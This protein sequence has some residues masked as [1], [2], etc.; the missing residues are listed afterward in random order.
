MPIPIGK[1]YTGNMIGQRGEGMKEVIN[2]LLEEHFE[3]GKSSLDFSC[4]NIE[5]SIE[6]GETKEGSFRIYSRQGS[7]TKGLVYTTDNRMECL[8]TQFVGN[9]EEIAY[10]FHGENVR[11]GEEIKGEFSIISN[12]GEYSLPFT[13]QVEKKEL[14]FSLG[15]VKNLFHFANLAK[16]NPE[17]AIAAFYAPDFAD[18]LTGQDRQYREYYLGLSHIPG[19]VENIEEFLIGIHKKQKIEYIVQPEMLLLDDPKEDEEA[20][21]MI[22]RNGWGYTDLTVETEGDFICISRQVLTEQDFMGNLCRLSVHID[23]SRLHDGNNLGSIALKGSYDTVKVPVAVKRQR[24]TNDYR[25][26][27]EKKEITLQLMQL[28]LDFRM[29]KIGAGSWAKESSRLTEELLSLNDGDLY[30]RLFHAQLLITAQ[31]IN[32]VKWILDHVSESLAQSAVEDDVLWAYYL[33]LTSL[34]SEEESYVNKVTDKVEKLYRKNKDEWRIAW[35]LL[36][37]SEEYNK[38]YSKRWMFLEEQLERGCSSP[39][40][41]TESLLLLNSNPSLLMHLGTQEKKL[42]YFGARHEMIS[43]DVVMQLTYLAGKEKEYDAFLL[44][45]LTACYRTAADDGL[46][47]EICSQLMKGNRTGKDYFTWYKLAVEREIRLTRLYE[48]YMQSMDTEQ[49]AGMEPIPKMVLMYFSYQNSLPY[50]KAAYL[51]ANVY[52]YRENYPEL[53][54]TYL[55]QMGQ[56]L[57]NQ[58]GKRRINKCLAYL[59]ENLLTPEMLMGELTDDFAQLAFL[60]EVTV[61]KKGIRR[62]VVYDPGMEGE[63]VYPVCDGKAY[64]S[65]PGADSRI[66]LEDEA[67]NRYMNSEFY[68]AEKLLT[69]DRLL[70][71]VAPLAGNLHDVNIYRCFDGLTLQEITPENEKH[72]LYLL[73]DELAGEKLKKEVAKRLLRYYFEQDRTEELQ[74]FLSN[75]DV[76]SYDDMESRNEILRYMVVRGMEDTAYYWLS[77]MGP[78]GIEP[79]VLMRLCSRWIEKTGYAEDSALTEMVYYA[80]THGKYDERC[81]RYL[82]LYAKGTIRM[83]RDIWKAAV[84]FCV[85]TYELNERMLT[86]MLF[87]GSFV[88]ERMQIF[89]SY[90]E[91]GARPEI[92]KAFLAECAY[93]YFVRDSVTDR[94]VFDEIAAMSRRGDGVKKISCLAY[95][96]YFAENPEEVDK[97]TLPL[98]AVFIRSLVDKGIMMKMFTAF[99]QITDTDILALQ[100]RTIVEY[101]ASSPDSRVMIY[102]RYAP[103]DS[104]VP[105]GNASYGRNDNSYFVEEMKKVYGGVYSKDFVLFYGESLQY[106]IM[107]VVQDKEQV[108]ES[109]TLQKSDTV[110]AEGSFALINDMSISSAMQDYATVDKLYEEYR[111][112][113]FMTGKLFTLR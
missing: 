26:R 22:T 13:V 50:N 112:K 80:F 47:R 70:K 28:Y 58:I 27:R 86:Q 75:V 63:K 16:T 45:I 59:Y 42:L 66:L 34:I 77:A 39:V 56:F 55:G 14:A 12:H 21:L 108:T 107:E 84:G 61:K 95:V 37:L 40:I 41:Y 94:F 8:T 52:K 25:Q 54:R 15:E 43:P 62:V 111:R 92:E 110:M 67:Q 11:E 88:G 29:K 74:A 106:Y 83:L 1:W 100:D 4:T 96:K 65:L 5:L 98:L 109:A 32:E 38:S 68:E 46:L 103:G 64:A 51:Y 48:F 102:Y 3:D 113:E 6:K 17:E 72:F 90:V 7:L 87:S 19:H 104:Y 33:Y 82:I 76:M 53:Y 31:R 57:I 97:D 60:Q 69:A 89:K 91:N 36:Y 35:L 10:R 71:A 78:Y 18:M 85:D 93:E 99:P 20:V 101:K 81:L 44:K 24:H 49:M 23:T 30:A 79:K 9:D 2:R 73:T 105:Q